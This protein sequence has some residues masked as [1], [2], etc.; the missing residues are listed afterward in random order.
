MKSCKTRSIFGGCGSMSASNLLANTVRG[1]TILPTCV[2]LLDTQWC[3]M[4]TR[5][6]LKTKCNKWCV[7]IDSQGSGRRPQKP[8]ISAWMANR[9]KKRNQTFSDNM[10]YCAALLVP[11]LLIWVSS[12]KILDGFDGTYSFIPHFEFKTLISILN[13]QFEIL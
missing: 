9:A 12:K 7:W 5:M 8:S 3:N 10:Y 4:Q 6:R 2:R 1:I 11:M 13:K